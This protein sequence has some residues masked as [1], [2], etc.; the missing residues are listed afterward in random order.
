ML[1]FDWSKPVVGAASIT[2]DRAP[3]Q[4]FDFVVWHFEDNYPRWAP[5]VIEFQSLTGRGIGVG[6]CYRQ[7]RLEQSQPVESEFTVAALEEAQYLLLQGT[8]APYQIRY[9]FAE[10]ADLA[11]TRLTFS[12]SLLELELFMK[13]FHKLIR[14]A[15]EEGAQYTVNNIK[16]L[17]ESD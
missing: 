7:I 14:V 13:P 12:F 8:T 16:S 10:V 1:A 15:I 11:A 3:L 17:I 2:I 5:E 6:A 4:V 9:E